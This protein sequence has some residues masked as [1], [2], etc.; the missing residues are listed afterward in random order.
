MSNLTPNMITLHSVHTPNG[1]RFEL[2]GLTEE[3]ITLLSIAMK[4]GRKEIAQELDQM[5]NPTVKAIAHAT[6]QENT[7]DRLQHISTR[8]MEISQ[9]LN[10]SAIKSH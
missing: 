7:A 5:R 6:N 9:A 2:R 10:S 4:P 1:N 8:L 3:D